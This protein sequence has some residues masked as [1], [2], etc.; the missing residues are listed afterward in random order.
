[1][2][3]KSVVYCFSGQPDQGCTELLDIVATS[4]VF[5]HTV[6]VVFIDDGVEHFFQSRNDEGPQDFEKTLQGIRMLEEFKIYLDAES[7]EE[8]TLP[9][10]ELPIDVAVIDST[11]ITEIIRGCDLAFSF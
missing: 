2:K 3:T 9:R 7:I 4:L 10:S 11:S 5:D 8:R 6:S 1:M